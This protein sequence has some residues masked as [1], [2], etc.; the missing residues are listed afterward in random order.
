MQKNITSSIDPFIRFKEQSMLQATIF[1]ASPSGN[2]LKF[3]AFNDLTHYLLN[4]Q[5]NTSTNN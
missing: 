5:R 2:A 3:K 4:D 1:F